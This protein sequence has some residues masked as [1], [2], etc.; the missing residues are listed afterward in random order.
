MIRYR[1]AIINIGITTLVYTLIAVF[2]RFGPFQFLYLPVFPILLIFFLIL[3]L[4]Y[5]ILLLS[6]KEKNPAKFI[7]RFILLTG[8]KFF[9]LFM[10]VLLYLIFNKTYVVSFLIYVL[11]LYAGYSISSYSVILTNNKKNK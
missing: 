8:I 11:I 4:A 7:N 6:P 1:T 2:L 9:F 3:Y 5:S 10:V